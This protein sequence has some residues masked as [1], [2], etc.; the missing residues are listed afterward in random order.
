MK[1]CQINLGFELSNRE[2]MRSRDGLCKRDVPKV[3]IILL[4]MSLVAYSLDG[5]AFDVAKVWQLDHHIFILAKDLKRT[6]D[7]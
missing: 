3:V 5:A 7:Q 1:K 6:Q 2:S 4:W